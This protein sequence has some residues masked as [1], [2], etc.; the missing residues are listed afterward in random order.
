MLLLCWVLRLIKYL[1]LKILSDL[2]HLL[3]FSR[4]QYFVFCILYF[5]FCILYFVFVILKLIKYLALKIPSS[6][7]AIVL[8]FLPL[9]SCQQENIQRH[10]I[11]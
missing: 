7:S 2:R 8:L 10:F 5:V 1:A 3:P 4:S 11:W 9:S 6:T